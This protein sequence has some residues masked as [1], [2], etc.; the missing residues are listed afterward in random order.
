MSLD[1]MELYTVQ[2]NVLIS[3]ILAID[4]KD[5]PEVR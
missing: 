1:L 3:D 2:Y 4:V 5:M